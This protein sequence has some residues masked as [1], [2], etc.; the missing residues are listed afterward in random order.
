MFTE[1]KLQENWERLRGIV[2]TEFTGERL[3]RLNKLY[4]HFEDRAVVTPASS[5]EH[6]HNSFPGGYVDHVL[7]VVDLA[8]KEAEM[9]K[10][11]NAMINF[12]REELVFSALHHDL[13]KVGD[14]EH[15]FYIPNDSQWHREKLGM[16]YKINDKIINTP[17]GMQTFYLLQYFG[18]VCTKFEMISI[19]CTDGLY[20]P[21]NESIL[22]PSD[23][24]RQLKTNLPLIMHHADH[25]ASR[26]E[27]DRWYQSK[28][29]DDETPQKVSN[30]NTLPP[31]KN[32]IKVVSS[33]KNVSDAQKLFDDLFK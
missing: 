14:L 27:Y 33:L 3:E 13:Y 22:K 24:N 9:W 5:K 16:I 19:Q 8:L 7:R 17:P 18:V 25:L 11:N 15:D 1:K 23:A 30:F 32:D 20:S 2:N 29:A 4:D 28:M 31:V 10:A 21:D 12:T 26:I 6:Y